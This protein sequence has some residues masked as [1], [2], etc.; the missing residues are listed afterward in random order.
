MVT[1]AAKIGESKRMPTL[2]TPRLRLQP[3]DEA[4]LDALH[5]L[6]NLPAVRQFLWDDQ[7]IARDDVAAIINRSRTLHVTEGEG[8]WVIRWRDEPQAALLGCIGYWYFHEP[9]QLEL[10]YS[11]DPACWGQGVATEAAT[12]LIAYGFEALAL[13]DIHA[14]TDAA[15]AASIRVLERLGFSYD[16]QT[17]NDNATIAHFVRS[18]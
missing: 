3:L 2:D 4:D 13:T 11:L 10:N 12:A 5:A 15:N 18:R 1:M 14:S 16:R 17:Q 7:P 6:W 8:L 9:P